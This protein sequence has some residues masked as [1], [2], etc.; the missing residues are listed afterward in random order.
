[1]SCRHKEKGM[2][3]WDVLVRIYRRRAN[4]TSRVLLAPMEWLITNCTRD[5]RRT[6][7]EAAAFPWVRTIEEGTMEIRRELEQLLLR[8]EEI[9]NFQDLSENQKYLTQG[10]QWKTFILYL[11]GKP[12][13]ENCLRCPATNRL[14][15]KIPRMKTAMFSILAPGKHIPMHYGVYKGVLRYHLGLIVPEPQSSCRIR[16]GADVRSWAEGQSLIFDDRYQHEAW[17]DSNSHRTVLFVDFVRPLP[18]PL[19]LLNRAAIWII[20]TTSLVR[21]ALDRARHRARAA[22]ALSGEAHT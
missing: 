14:L 20:S 9:P 1:M 6:F 18:L 8:R 5:G 19:D 21:T 12:V 22:K 16:V 10:E 7:F 13:E 17:N 15:R 4:F 3:K 2:I 11:Y